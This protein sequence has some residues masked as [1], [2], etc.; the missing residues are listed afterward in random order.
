MNCST[1]YCLGDALQIHGMC[2]V[3]IIL[4]SHNGYLLIFCITKGLK[5]HDMYL[6]QCC[7]ICLY[8]VLNPERFFLH[9]YVIP[10]IALFE[11]SANDKNALPVPYVA[12]T[13]THT[14]THTHKHTDTHTRAR[15]H[16]RSCLFFRL[17]ESLVCKILGCCNMTQ[18]F[19]PRRMRS[20][21]C[22]A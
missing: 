10:S 14:H 13:H 8:I 3:C 11:V 17:S 6:L 22:V 1:S 21:Q 18:N 20:V 4:L 16:A 12:H 7:L 2:D 15:T 9:I 5:C 19:I